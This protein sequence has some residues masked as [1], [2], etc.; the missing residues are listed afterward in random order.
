MDVCTLIVTGAMAFGCYSA[1]EGHKS[2]P[3]MACSNRIAPSS[4]YNCVRPD[5]TVYTL[6]YNMARDSKR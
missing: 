2:V 6:P 5:G 1:D 3:T 4:W